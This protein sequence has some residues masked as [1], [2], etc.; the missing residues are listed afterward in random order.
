MMNCSKK[1]SKHQW[2]V[3]NDREPYEEWINLNFQ[4]INTSRQTTF[5]IN[6]QKTYNVGHNI[7]NNKFYF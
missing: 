2:L 6:L 4:Q 3:H 1:Y 5:I 7:L